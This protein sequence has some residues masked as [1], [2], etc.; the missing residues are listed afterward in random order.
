MARIYRTFAVALFVPLAVACGGATS[1]DTVIRPGEWGSAD[2]SLRVTLQG[3]TMELAAGNCYGSFA[4]VR[5]SI[6]AEAFELD[7]TFTQ[8]MG[9]YPG[10]VEFPA[11]ISGTVSGNGI[12][13]TVAVPS[14]M[15]VIG[16]Y[17]LR[18]GVDP[19]LS[20]CLYP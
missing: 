10:Y 13:I 5:G 19:G 4:S 11:T 18:H 3:A 1:H 16:P 20:P 8:R 9:A 12:T 17:T 14:L 15:R 2:A 7:G 6:P